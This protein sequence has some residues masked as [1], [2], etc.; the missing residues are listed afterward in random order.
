MVTWPDGAGW[1]W[2]GLIAA[3]GLA[4]IAAI[5]FPAGVAH[6]HPDFA[7][8]PLRLAKAMLVPALTE[9]LAFRGLLIPARG[10]S[11]RPGLWI[12]GGLLLFVAWHVVEAL[13]FL[14]GAHLFLT[15]PFLACAAILGA[16]CVAMRYRTGSVWPGVIFHGLTVFLWQAACGGP[17]A[18]QLLK[19]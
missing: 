4:A 10:E 15:A 13:T 7:G 11:A 1:A 3:P 14:P 16:A 17:D 6:W 5:A 18:A 9:E 8:W 2:S 19:P 12:A